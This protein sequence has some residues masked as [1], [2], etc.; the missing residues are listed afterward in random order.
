MTYAGTCSV[1]TSRRRRLNGSAPDVGAVSYRLRGGVPMLGRRFGF[2][3]DHVRQVDVVT[4]DA[5]CARSAP[6]AIPTCSGVFRINH[7]IPPA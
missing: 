6:T 1:D 3:A 2:A 7:N 5:G 4:A